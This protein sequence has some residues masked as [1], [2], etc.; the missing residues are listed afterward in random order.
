MIGSRAISR[1][2][3]AKDVVVP[4]GGIEC[5]VVVVDQTE[6]GP[7]LFFANHDGGRSPVNDVSDSDGLFAAMCEDAVRRC[8]TASDVPCVITFCPIDV[9][10]RCSPRGAVIDGERSS[11][12]LVVV[13]FLPERFLFEERHDLIRPTPFTAISGGGCVDRPCAAAS[14]SGNWMH[15]SVAAIFS[16]IGEKL[17]GIMVIVKRKA[18]LFQ[19]ILTLSTPCGLASFLDRWKQQGY[20][21][22]DD[23][24]D[25]QQL[26]QREAT[27]CGRLTL[28]SLGFS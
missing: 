26:D 9:D 1:A 19:L 12:Q 18:D 25:D 11:L 23:R 7:Q 8:G 5:L 28:L 3:I 16:S 27:K 4:T 14:R 15:R 21:H 22:S 13:R 24:D 17:I 20:Q 6:S 2:A 10:R